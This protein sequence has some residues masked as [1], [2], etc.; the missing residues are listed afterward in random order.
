MRNKCDGVDD[1]EKKCK[2]FNT[3][4]FFGVA[5]DVTLKKVGLECYS[6]KVGWCTLR[7]ENGR[8]GRVACKPF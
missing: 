8:M 3:F 4:S 7:K 2:Y 6:P 1:D 5:G